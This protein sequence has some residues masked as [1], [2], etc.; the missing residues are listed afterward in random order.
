M[1]VRLLFF[2]S[3][4]TN[5]ELSVQVDA[6]IDKAESLS[7]TK[8]LCSPLRFRYILCYV[9][10]KYNYTYMITF[11]FLQWLKMKLYCSYDNDEI[12][13]SGYIYVK[14]KYFLGK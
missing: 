1:A 3:Y 4:L 13:C 2:E 6:L 7:R 11:S 12:P 14:V 8:L 9:L 10:L 5:A